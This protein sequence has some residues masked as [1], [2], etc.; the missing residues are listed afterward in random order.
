[1]EHQQQMRI[2]QGL[3]QVALEFHG[4]TLMLINSTTRCEERLSSMVEQC[5][6]CADTPA[7]C[8]HPQWNISNKHPQRIAVL[9]Q[10]FHAGTT[11]I[12]SEYT[13]ANDT[14]DTA[15]T[16]PPWNMTSPK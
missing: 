14:A 15:N 10:E 4:G 7:P 6:R 3:Q 1:M 8:I 9:G 2:E 5:R 12:I 16:V 11:P 13:I